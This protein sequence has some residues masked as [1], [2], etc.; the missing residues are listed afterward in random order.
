MEYNK[1]SQKIH[2]AQG[3]QK[4]RT[5]AKIQIKCLVPLKGN[6]NKNKKQSTP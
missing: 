4:R 6:K 2:L 1:S 5:L 3:I